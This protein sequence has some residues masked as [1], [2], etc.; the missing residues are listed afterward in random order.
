MD[1]PYS[2][3]DYV[4]DLLAYLKDKGIKKPHVIAHSFGARVALKACYS[5][6]EAFDR[7]VLTGAAGL[8]PKPSFYK[9][10]KKLGYKLLKPLLTHNARLKFYS[11]DYR[12]LDGVMRQSFQKIVAE[13]LDYVLP[14][15]KNQTLI[16]FGAQDKE[17][18]LYMAERLYKGISNSEKVI[19]NDAGH[20]CFIDKPFTFNM[21]VR[22]FLLSKK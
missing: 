17:T 15:I 5:H 9:V 11:S 22:E 18:P 20:F 3:D 8:K 7:L 16:V 6:P 2:L 10:L 14:A 4:N 12:A 13:H 21:E 1:Y 19:I